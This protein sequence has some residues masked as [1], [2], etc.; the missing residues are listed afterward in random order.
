M[1]FITV[2]MLQGRAEHNEMCLSTLEEVALHQQGIEK[3]ELLNQVCRELKICL[4]QNNLIPK[5][6]NLNR[7]KKLE[8]LNLA[9]NNIT[10]IEN[11]EGCES[12]TKLDF[13]ANFIDVDELASIESLRHNLFLREI[14]FTGNPITEWPGYRDYVVAS[15]P[16]LHTLDGKDVTKSERIKAMQQLPQLQ[17]QLR[18]D[19]E[20][21]RQQ[22]QWK[23]DNPKTPEYEYNDKTGEW[24]ELRD[25]SPETRCA[26][27]FENAKL[28]EEQEA[29]RQKSRKEL[30]EFDEPTRERRFFTDDGRP[31]QMNTG[32]WPFHLNEDDKK[33][34]MLL[35][36]TL[37]RHLDSAQIDADVQPT[38]VRVQAKKKWFQLQLPEECC[39]D[40][41]VAKRSLTTGHLLITM[42]RVKQTIARYGQKQQTLQLPAPWEKTEQL[43]EQEKENKAVKSNGL[44]DAVDIHHIVN[45]D[46]D[47]EE[48][49]L[50]VEQKA[51]AIVEL[52]NGREHSG[53]SK[54]DLG[55]DSDEVPPLE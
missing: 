29:A 3:I 40:A 9:L 39:A 44:K 34:N 33:G 1:P 54:E 15:L 28:Q 14:Y 19:A 16:Q 45:R 27:Y 17:Q 22:K 53:L 24:E 26:D 7:L 52:A 32:R 2:K 48:E 18:Q 37:P 41:A 12:L 55:Y 35:D 38:Y 47:D 21:K 51:G 6:E 5:L 10:K 43:Q 31:M 20:S 23:R 42:P 50:M 4:M 49:P 8:Y 13:T 25:W 46:S 36:I 30:W 11:L